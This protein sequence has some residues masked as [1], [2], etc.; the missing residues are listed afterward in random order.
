MRCRKGG[1]RGRREKR[2][3]KYLPILILN[4]ESKALKFKKL[5]HKILSRKGKMR[6]FRLEKRENNGDEQKDN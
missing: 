4:T 1:R 5:I 6:F 3:N 2:T